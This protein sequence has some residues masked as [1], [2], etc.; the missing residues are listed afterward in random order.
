MPADFSAPEPAKSR[1]TLFAWMIVLAFSM[2][3]N[4]LWQELGGGD[5]G[6]L[7]AVKLGLLALLVGVS[8]L[9]SPLR[10]LRKF[11]I[12][13]LAIYGIEELVSRAAQAPLWQAWFGGADLPFTQDML[14]QQLQRLAVS[15]LIILALLGLGL[16]RKDF[17]LVRGNLRAPI[18][19]VRWLGFPKPDPW[20]HFGGQFAVYIS[21]GLLVFLIIGG[22]PSLAALPRALPMLPMI[23]LLAAMNAFNEEMTYR[24]SMISTLEGPLG[25]QGAVLAAAS[26]FGIGH[27][28]GVPYGIIGVVMATFLGW[29]LGKAMV[30]TRG[31]CW[32]WFIHFLQDVL[33][34]SFMAIGSITPGG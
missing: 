34:F 21:L 16:K 27:F 15:A 18:T 5:A 33:I 24:S 14:G 7:F 13:L 10:P 11:I 8:F 9:W 22:R 1:V 3:P 17:F 29:L 4:I 31:F 2:L 25:S 20:T 32:A 6:W 12:I 30:E 26:F 19:P 23:L 28:Y